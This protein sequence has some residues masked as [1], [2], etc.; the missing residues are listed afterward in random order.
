MQIFFVIYD[1][2][3][4]LVFFIYL[5]FYFFRKK[6]NLAA[7]KEKFSF[8][9]VNKKNYIW[10]HAV[11]VGEVILIS[12]L[13]RRLSENFNLPILITT[14][15]L[16]GKKVAEKNFSNIAEIHFFPYDISIIIKRFLRIVKPKIFIAVETE[17]WP[18]LFYNLKRKNIPIL[19]INARISDK[20][21][22]RYYFFKAF[23]SK[24]LKNCDAISVQNNFYKDRF[25]LLGY[26]EKKLVVSGNLKFESISI[27]SEQLIRIQRLYLP[28]LKKDEDQFLFLAASTHYPEE[29]IIL[30]VYKNLLNKFSNIVLLIAPRHIERTD[31]IEKLAILNNFYPF[32]I[33]KISLDFQ[34]N[35]YEKDV[36][37]I[38]DTVGELI[39]FYSLADICFVGG[40]LVKFG[41]HNILEPIY[42][43]KPTFFGPFMDN[44]KD[45]VDIVLDKNAAVRVDNKQ[46]LETEISKILINKDLRRTFQERCHQ[47]FEN[48]KTALEKNFKLIS[49]YITT[50]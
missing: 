18:N 22:R 34:K 36:I 5:P 6:I 40:S 35:K 16:S 32:R 41:G 24:I 50:N 17:I 42:F 9:K 48:Q 25:I 49:K 46:Q 21:F 19:I 28:I 8:V 37:Y 44:F 4:L 1:I 11:S 26:P 14:T 7:L 45:I 29:K 23:V 10:I 31:E 39:Y 38:L 30:E 12:S 27:N 3:F 13:I 33:S 15:T 2:V 20:A 43:G 47:V